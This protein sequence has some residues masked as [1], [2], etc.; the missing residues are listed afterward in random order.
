LFGDS[1]TG[2]FTDVPPEYV[3]DFGTTSL[4]GH[5]GVE[6]KKETFSSFPL[7]YPAPQP[8]QKVI[9]MVYLTSS[10]NIEDP[11]HV[12]ELN[13]G[14]ILAEK[15][16]GKGYARQAIDLVATKAFE[17][18]KCHR[19]QAILLNH[20]AKDRALCLFTEMCVL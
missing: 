17:G 13:I 3:N 9:G 10:R 5:G 16:R 15:Y 19:L 8:R 12:G 20:V 11:F 7:D 14:I 1:N 18:F 2:L 4:W 6:V